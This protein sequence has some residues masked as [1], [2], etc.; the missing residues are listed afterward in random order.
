M[1]R[2]CNVLLAGFVGLALFAPPVAVG[3]DDRVRVLQETPISPNSD[4][5]AAV[6]DECRDIGRELPNAIA[7]SSRNVALVKTD[8]ELTSKRG[9]YLTI[10]ITQVRA[11]G[12]SVFTGPK[13]LAVRG[14][15]YDGGKEIGDFEGDRSSMGLTSTCAS[16]QKAEKT[17]GKEIARW[18]ESPRAH[19]RL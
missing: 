11:K 18:L 1:S 13:H 5:P 15:L 19:S 4:I 7:R 16:L 17:L 6:R 14:T 8:K 9:K 2:L 3:A 12:G 10:E